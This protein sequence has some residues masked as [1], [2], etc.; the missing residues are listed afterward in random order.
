ME[1]GHSGPAEPAVTPGPAY[2]EHPLVVAMK[3]INPDLITPQQ[4]LEILYN[5]KKL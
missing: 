2:R 3:N 1:T 5:L 4:A